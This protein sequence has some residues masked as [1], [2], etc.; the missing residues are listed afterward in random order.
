MAN[1]YSFAEHSLTV[2]GE[3]DTL[4]DMVAF[5]E[6]VRNAAGCE[7]PNTWADLIY[8]IKAEFDE[9]FRQQIEGG[10]KMD[11]RKPIEIY[12]D[13]LTESKQREILD[14]LGD[15]G[16]YDVFPIATIEPEQDEELTEGDLT[17]GSIQ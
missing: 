11:E 4:L 3:K 8:S 10:D 6:E 13:D 14:A 15:N 1:L 2:T 17:L 16:N 9:E 12:W 5:Y 7:L